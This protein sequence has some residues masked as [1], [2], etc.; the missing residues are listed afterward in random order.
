MPGSTASKK[1]FAPRVGAAYRLSERTVIRAGYGITVDPD[2]MRN[3][4]N[5]YP[6]IVN[7]VYQP[8][9]SYEFISYAGVPNSNGSPRVS[10]ADGL[11]LPTFPDITV[12][13]IKP[14]TTASPTTYLPSI[15]TVTFPAYFNR[16]YYQTWNFTVQHEF[17]PSLMAQ[18]G[19]VGTHGVHTN[20]GVNINGSAPG[21]GTAGRQLYPYVTSDMNEYEPF[22]DNT[23]N[24][25]Q[26]TVRKRIGASIIGASYTFSK[27]IN[28]YNGDN[29]D[30]TLWR[31][32]PTSFTLDKQIAGFD[33]PHNFQLYYVYQLPFGRGH[34]WL[35]HGWESWIVGNWQLSGT[36]S[37]ES[38]LPF[39]VGTTSNINAGGQADSATQIAPVEIL[40]GHDQND[41]Y[42]SG[43]SF[44]NPPNGVLGSTGHYLGGV[45]GPGL[46]AWN[47]SISRIFPFK[48]GKIKFQLQGE[49]YNLTNTVVFANPG[50]SCCWSTTAAGTTNYN[51]FGVISA[52][53]STPRYLVVAGYLRF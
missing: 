49:A 6:A 15:S 19:Y 13:I 14:A 24:A 17:S 42:F 9:N 2:N 23:Y 37:R 52:T 36:L 18:V 21:T 27:A 47:A 11:P 10:L 22:G 43:S 5:Q 20:M 12:G 16:G 38:G 30:A 35:N 4:R 32:Y 28:N 50:G 51:G 53:Q 34:A 31:A 46:F 25:L 3:Q 8:L 26:A 7:Q 44:T 41:P 29:G 40:G 39:G 1:D 48:E 33:R 45:F